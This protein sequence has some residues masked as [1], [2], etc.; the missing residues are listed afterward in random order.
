MHNY[1]PK[2]LQLLVPS[3]AA[4]CII[5]YVQHEPQFSE[6]QN[7]K[8]NN[9]HTLENGSHNVIKGKVYFKHQYRQ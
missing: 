5:M 4:T 7:E 3:K 6:G 8:L 1:R 2:Q 9:I